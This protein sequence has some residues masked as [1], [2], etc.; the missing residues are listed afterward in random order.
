MLE[1]RLLLNGCQFP[2]FCLVHTSESVH[3]CND[4]IRD[5]HVKGVNYVLGS[6]T[7]I[8]TVSAAWVDQ[9]LFGWPAD[10]QPSVER[11]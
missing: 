11:G 2:S 1:W 9:G 6:R 4:R 8:A 7:F 5:V 10:L 3:M